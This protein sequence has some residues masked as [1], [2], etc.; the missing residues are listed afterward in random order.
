MRALGSALGRG[1]AL[2]D[3]VDQELRR[4]NR[5]DVAEN[6]IGT[7]FAHARRDDDVATLALDRER[8]VLQLALAATD[9]LRVIPCEQHVRSA[10]GAAVLAGLE[11]LVPG[12]ERIPFGDAVGL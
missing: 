3:E 6:A 4:F 9:R 1:L 10:G 7:A 8:E 2:R 11:G 5:I 12:D